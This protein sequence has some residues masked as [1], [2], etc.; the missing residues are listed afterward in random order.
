M[1][2]SRRPR[3]STTSLL[4]DSGVTSATAPEGR[5]P[6]PKGPASPKG[7]PLAQRARRARSRGPRGRSVT[8]NERGGGHAA[9][10]G[11]GGGGAVTLLLSHHLHEATDGGTRDHDRPWPRLLVEW[12][13]LIDLPRCC[14]FMI[15]LLPPPPTSSSRGDQCCCRPLLRRLGLA[16]RS[17]IVKNISFHAGCCGPPHTRRVA[18]YCDLS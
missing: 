5:A 17:S 1:S 13:L 6:R 12:C 7:E 10:R 16:H 2:V 11:G 14:R 4:R 18:S 3:C 9:P 8:T 15:F